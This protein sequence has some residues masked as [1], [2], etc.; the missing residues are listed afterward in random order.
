MLGV[1]CHPKASI[2]HSLPAYKIWRL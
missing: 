2:W 1:I